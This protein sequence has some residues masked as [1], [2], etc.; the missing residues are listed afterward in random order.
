[1]RVEQNETLWNTDRKDCHVRISAAGL[2]RTFHA[3]PGL[4]FFSKRQRTARSSHRVC[5]SR[6]VGQRLAILVHQG[7]DPTLPYQALLTREG[8]RLFP[9]F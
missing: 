9:G 5:L 1:M 8:A 7:S 2:R 3:P 4:R 6:L